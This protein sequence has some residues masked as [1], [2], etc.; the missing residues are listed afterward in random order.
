MNTMLNWITVYLFM[1]LKLGEYSKLLWVPSA[2][3]ERKPLF[4]VN[5][6]LLQGFGCKGLVNMPRA[7]TMFPPNDVSPS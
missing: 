7:P 5:T 1:N 6:L 3:L 2:D 4:Y